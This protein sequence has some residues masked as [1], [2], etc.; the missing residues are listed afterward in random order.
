MFYL[1]DDL[2]QGSQR[3]L[4]WRKGVIGDSEAGSIIGENPWRSAERLMMEKLGLVPAF[5][6]NTK[7]R[8]GQR[9]EPEA[10]SAVE[11]FHSTRIRPKVIQDSEVPYLA[12]SL[13]GITDDCKT[14]YE[15]KCGRS[16]YERTRSTGKP[17]F[18]DVAQL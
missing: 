9:L 3:W 10:R 7:T 4:H 6:G 1:L 12:A 18:Y 13:D 15:I 5:Q 8:E 2:Q 17:P 16:A 11:K 14:A